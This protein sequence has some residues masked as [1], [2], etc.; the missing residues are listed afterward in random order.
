MLVILFFGCL[1]VVGSLKCFGSERLIFWRESASGVY[2]MAFFV[3]QNLVELPVVLLKPLIYVW[4][5]Y[6]LA[7]PPISS[8]SAF[9]G[10]MIGL[11]WSCSG[12]GYVLS[13]VLP[14]KNATL[15][16][17]IFSIMMGAFMS[18]IKPSLKAS[19]SLLV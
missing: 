16:S 14:A 6:A 9:I 12:Y 2:T 3:S 19:E 7:M 15:T 11:S 1:S 8:E 18:G 17:V 5:Y 4:V 10:I 13:I